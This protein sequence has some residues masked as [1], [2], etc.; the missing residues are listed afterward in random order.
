MKEE[1]KKH[2]EQ[3]KK[4]IK[5]LELEIQE[6]KKRGIKNSK[7]SRHSFFFQASKQLKE[8]LS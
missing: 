5:E 1:N 4:T 7:Q 2:L 3:T 8:C 6:Q